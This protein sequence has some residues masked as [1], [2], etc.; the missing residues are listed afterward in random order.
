M[1]TVWG[2]RLNGDSYDRRTRGR[3]DTL[4]MDDDLADSRGEN[5]KAVAT[6]TATDADRPA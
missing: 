5:Q 3:D 1:V 4:V 2:R 6:L